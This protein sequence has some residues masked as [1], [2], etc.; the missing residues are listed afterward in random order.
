M[1]EKVRLE[2]LKYISLHNETESRFL[3]ANPNTY[4]EVIGLL[5]KIA[6]LSGIEPLQN[7]R[8]FNKI[9]NELM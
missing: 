1:S 6:E 3:T 7:G 2:L 4:I 9:A 8:D 5:D